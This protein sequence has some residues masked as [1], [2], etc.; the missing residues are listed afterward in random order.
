MKSINELKENLQ[1]TLLSKQ[2]DMNLLKAMNEEIISKNLVLDLGDRL[3]KNEDLSVEELNK[4]E[5]IAITTATYNY[6]RDESINPKN[7]FSNAELLEYTD[8]K[9]MEEEVKTIAT[10][11]NVIKIDARNYLFTITDKEIIELMDNRLISYNK[12]LQRPTEQITRNGVTIQ[13][14]SINQKNMEEMQ[15]GF[16]KGNKEIFISN[17]IFGIVDREQELKVKYDK[18]KMEMIIQPSFTSATDTSLYI[19]DGYHRMLSAYLS[20]KNYYK[21]HGEYPNVIFTVTLMINTFD[22]LKN[23]VVQTFKRTQVDVDWINTNEVT[24][25]NKLVDIVCEDSKWISKMLK[26]KSYNKVTIKKT[27]EKLNIDIST[28]LKIENNGARIAKNIDNLMTYIYEEYLEQDEER[29]NKFLFKQNVIV[30]LLTMI[31]K[32]KNNKQI[33]ELAGQLMKTYNFNYTVL[34]NKSMK[35]EGKLKE[36]DYD[37]I[38]TTYNKLTERVI[39][40]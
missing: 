37:I 24:D 35:L 39:K 1:F 5:L 21:Q 14:I 19:I 6:T 32:C 40:E 34:T 4:M 29:A 28:E 26:N 38:I 33:I 9:V 3:L 12:S 8:F 7:Y 18:D 10:F 36:A 16:K 11:H 23:S 2:T 31:V 25:I 15:E 17:L 30:G 20:A 27:L 13:K 22:Y